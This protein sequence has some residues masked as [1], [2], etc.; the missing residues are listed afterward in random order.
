[1]KYIIDVKLNNDKSF[2]SEISLHGSKKHHLKLKASISLRRMEIIFV[3]SKRNLLPN[4]ASSFDFAFVN[5]FY[6]Q[7]FVPKLAGNF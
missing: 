5:P 7:Q 4:I 1:M 6:R 2:W 3:S